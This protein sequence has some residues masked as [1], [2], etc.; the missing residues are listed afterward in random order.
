MD[1]DSVCMAMLNHI[2]LKEHDNS[3]DPLLS[4]G[5]VTSLGSVTVEIKN[6]WKYSSFVVDA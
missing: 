2:N 5:I 4:I 3:D 6:A 1:S